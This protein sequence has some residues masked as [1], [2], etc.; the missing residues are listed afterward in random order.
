MATSRA[1]LKISGIRGAS[2]DCSHVSWI[3]VLT[4]V[5]DHNFIGAVGRSRIGGA[6]SFTKLVDVSTPS[7]FEAV[8][9]AQHHDEAILETFLIDGKTQPNQWRFRYSDIVV[10]SLQAAA[11]GGGDRQ[12]EQFVMSYGSRTTSRF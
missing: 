3:E 8:T 6:T 11:K 2:V 5:L 9:S 1:Y 12:V 4:F 7:L 10:V